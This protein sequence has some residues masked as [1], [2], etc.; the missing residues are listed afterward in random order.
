M[1]AGT[2]IDE[3]IKSVE[4][5]EKHARDEQ[6]KQDFPVYQQQNNWREA[7]EVA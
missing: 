5:A 6:K 7:V 1:F 4:R 2:T 3:L